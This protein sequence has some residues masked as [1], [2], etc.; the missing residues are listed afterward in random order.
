[1][2][3]HRGHNDRKHDRHDLGSIRHA[4]VGEGHGKQA[5]DS[6]GHD[7]TRSNP[8]HEELFSGSDTRACRCQK[9]GHWPNQKHHQHDEAGSTQVERSDGCGIQGGSQQQEEA[10]DQEN[11]DGLLE[12]TQ[13]CQA[14]NP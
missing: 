12:S 13:F 4:I 5:T 3:K 6:H 1:M 2:S 14:G 9:D 11:G 10:R 7:P 8:A